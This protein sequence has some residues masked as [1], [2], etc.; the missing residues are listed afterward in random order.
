MTHKIGWWLLPLVWLAVSCS[1]NE[2]P[3]KTVG[4]AIPYT[5]APNRTLQ[6]L[7][8]SIPTLRIYDSIYHHSDLGHLLDSLRGAQ[9]AK[10]YTLFAPADEAFQKA[11]ITLSQVGSYAPAVLDSIAFYLAA[12]GSYTTEGLSTL[13]GYQP[14]N[15]LLQ[16]TSIQSSYQ[17]QPWNPG[18]GFSAQNPYIYTLYVGWTNG[19][20]MQ[21]GRPVGANQGIQATDGVLWETDTLVTKPTQEAYA[22]IAGDTSFSFFMAAGEISDSIYSNNYISVSRPVYT[23]G[24][25]TVFLQLMAGLAPRTFFVPT[26]NAFR[27]AGFQSVTDIYNYILQS[28]N[29]VSGNFYDQNYNVIV[30]NMDSILNYHQS[31]GVFYTQDMLSDPSLNMYVESPTGAGQYNQHPVYL[32]LTFSNVNG[33][34]VLH[35]Q[36]FPGGR[37]ATVVAP[38][39]MTTLNGVVH[40]VDNLLLPQP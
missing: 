34:V 35:R 8:D 26:N 10:Y 38:Y 18:N 32:Y 15:T 17:G 3:P 11:G 24:P 5:G 31:T 23:S 19:T 9:G 12:T 16:V 13:Q 2:E 30:T 7:I 25:D 29:V 39:D 37:A 21:N 36:D 28:Y 33:Q 22:V 6:A 27:K 40:S 20:L 14:L 4:Q 1:K